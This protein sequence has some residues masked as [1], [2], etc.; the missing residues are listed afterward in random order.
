MLISRQL[1]YVHGI[2]WVLL[3]NS[4][5]F[6]NNSLLRPVIKTEAYIIGA[7]DNMVECEIWHKR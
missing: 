1:Y 4:S 6:H 5:V 7:L 3:P 2:R